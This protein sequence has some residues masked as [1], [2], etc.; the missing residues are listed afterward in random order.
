M[1]AGQRCGLMQSHPGDTIAPGSLLCAPVSVGNGAWGANLI[2]PRA[3]SWGPGVMV[4][5]GQPCHH[6]CSLF[7]SILISPPH[8]GQAEQGHSHCRDDSWDERPTLGP[9]QDGDPSR[10]AACPHILPHLSGCWGRFLPSRSPGATHPG[11]TS[12]IQLLAS[13]SSPGCRHLGLWVPVVPTSSAPGHRHRHPAVI[14]GELGW[15]K[16]GGQGPDG[17][18]LAAAGPGLRGPGQPCPARGGCL[19]GAFPSSDRWSR[20]RAAAPHGLDLAQG[21]RSAMEGQHRHHGVG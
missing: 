16:A 9:Q 12:G 20:I 21:E 13:P 3:V 2:C 18:T 4:A 10:T 5:L 1:Q 6:P 19:V 15:A 11:C 17:A 14:P 8:G 7:G